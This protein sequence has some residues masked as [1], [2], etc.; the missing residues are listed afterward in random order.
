MAAKKATRVFPFGGQNYL[1]PRVLAQAFA[2][3]TIAAAAALKSDEFTRWLA[4]GLHDEDIVQHYEE[5]KAIAKRMRQGPEEERWVTAAVSTI[6]PTGP[7]RYRGI[8]VF[9]FGLANAIALATLNEQ[10]LQP[11][12]EIIVNDLPN[13]WLGAQREKK[14]ELVGMIQQ[15]ERTKDMVEKTGLGFGV[16]RA[17]YEMSPQQ[18]CLS[19]PLRSAYA[20]NL[21]ELMEAID[22]R[23]AADT[24]FIDRHVAAF[25]LARDK[26]ILA[27]VMRAVETATEPGKRGL[28]LLTLFAD[29]QYRH[30]PDKLRGIGRAVLPLADETVRRFQ[31]RPRQGKTR[32]ALRAAAEEGDLA[33]MLRLIDDPDLLAFDAQEYDAARLLY[34][35]TEA[36]IQRLSNE[37]SNKKF[38]AEQAGQPLASAVSVAIAFCLAAFLIIRQFMMG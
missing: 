28:A 38:L 24:N 6:D 31:N 2:K 18:P 23:S 11:F 29:L 7:I 16:E 14:P 30:G 12:A 35:A 10:S 26:R 36:E 37:G 9:P 17:L 22:R 15:I 3:E 32:E 5:M 21:R 19:P 33:E 8:A 25:M 4:H 13:S 34:A 1:Q 27:Q 20:M